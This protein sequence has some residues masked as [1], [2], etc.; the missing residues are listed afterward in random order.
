MPVRSSKVVGFVDSFLLVSSSSSPSSLMSESNQL[1]KFSGRF[2]TSTRPSRRVCS[3]YY[4]LP[5][6]SYSLLAVAFFG[7]LAG[8]ILSVIAYLLWLYIIYQPRVAD[9]EVIVQPEDRLRPGQVGAICIPV[10]LFI[11]AWTSR[12]R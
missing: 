7:I 11:F 4:Q 6:H 10:C 2:I 9:P 12:Q 1:P 5:R 3:F 8:A